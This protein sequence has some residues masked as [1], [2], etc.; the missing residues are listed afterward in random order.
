MSVVFTKQDYVDYIKLQLTGGVIELEISDDIIGRYVDQALIE[1]RRYIDQEVFITVPFA[2]CIDLKGFNHS[3][4]TNVY[5]V[6]GFTG[7]TMES[8][9]TSDVDP[10]YAQQ[11]LAFSS[12]GTVYNLKSY[13]MNYASYNTLL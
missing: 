2:K 8:N 6:Q 10:M 1:I 3:A 7:D 4:I 9:S 13:I 12:G 11:W 5:R